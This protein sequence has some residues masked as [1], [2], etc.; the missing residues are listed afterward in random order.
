MGY[1]LE[2]DIQRNE[3]RLRA[4]VLHIA[5]RLVHR[6]D[7]QG[8]GAAEQGYKFVSAALVPAAK[9]ATAAEPQRD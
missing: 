4:G 3:V 5:D 2:A 7:F 8:L 1:P 9:F 6:P